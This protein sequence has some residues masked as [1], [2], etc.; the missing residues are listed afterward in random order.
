MK[1]LSIFLILSCALIAGCSTAASNE[2]LTQTSPRVTVYT[3]PVDAEII[4]LLTARPRSTTQ[5]GACGMGKI[6]VYVGSNTTGRREF[7]GIRAVSVFDTSPNDVEAQRKGGTFDFDTD[8]KIKVTSTGVGAETE[9]E[10]KKIDKGGHDALLD[11]IWN[12]LFT[13]IVVV[14]SLWLAM[15]LYRPTRPIA[16]AMT[17]TIKSWFTGKN[18]KTS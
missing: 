17:S 10:A 15:Y 3:G 4:A 16:L 1:T 7:A 11:R 6:T 18:K 14:G 13:I 5:P 9:S 12:K 2:S 8:S